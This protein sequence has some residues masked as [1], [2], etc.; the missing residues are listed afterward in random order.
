MKN[1]KKREQHNRQNLW[2]FRSLHALFLSA[3]GL[4]GEIQASVSTLLHPVRCL[5]DF[6]I[7]PSLIS[8]SPAM[9]T[10]SLPILT[11]SYCM[12]KVGLWNFHQMEGTLGE[13]DASANT[14]GPAT[15]TSAPPSAAFIEG[16]GEHSTSA[17]PT[18]T[19]PPCRMKLRSQDSTRAEQASLFDN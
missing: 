11:C 9:H 16:Q 18:P 8:T 1:K 10:M 6:W 19:T 2:Q 14:E 3:A 4:R 17:T 13:G 7:S 15:P 12:R 5:T